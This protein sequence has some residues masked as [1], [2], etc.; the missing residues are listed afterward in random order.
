[1]PSAKKYLTASIQIQVLLGRVNKL[2]GNRQ[3]EV[4]VVERLLPFVVNSVLSSWNGF[5]VP[6]IFNGLFVEK[7]M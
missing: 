1:M 3:Y 6:K 2:F 5:L 4:E 7:K